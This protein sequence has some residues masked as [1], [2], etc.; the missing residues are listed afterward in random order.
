M[1]L[2]GFFILL[3]LTCFSGVT[4]AALIKYTD[5]SAFESALGSFTVDGFEDMT[6]NG[7][8]NQGMTRIDY[9]FDMNSYR[10]VDSLTCGDNSADG[11]DYKYIWT[12]SSGSFDFKNPINAFGLDFDRYYN[13]GSSGIAS[14]TLNDVDHSV[15]GSGF[16]GL[17]DTMNPFTSVKYIAPGSGSL[18][19]NVTY[20]NAV[21]VPE[22]SNIALLAAG[23]LG[24]GFARRRK[25][26]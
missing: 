21:S 18:F 2:K 19:D 7:R 26:S 15:T 14:V 9:S 16:L 6:T 17:I 13:D 20:S 4:N 10:C 1:F 3:G 5:R 25:P 22:P 23:L 12:I 24:L 11:F 8:Q